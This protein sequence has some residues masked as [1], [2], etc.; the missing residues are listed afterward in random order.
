MWQQIEGILRQAMRETADQTAAF[1]PG[2]LVSLVLFVAV[3]VIAV[4][5][6]VAVIRALKGIEFDR[7]AEQFGISGVSVW[8]TSG[9]LSVVIGRTLQWT[10]L[11]LGLLLSLTALNATIPSRLAIVIIEYVPHLFAALMILV[12][13]WL[14][15]QLLARSTLIGAVNMQIRSARL[16]SLAVKW[17]VLLVAV[18]MALDHLGIG[19][20]VLLL[21]FGILFG[22]IVL[23]ASIA[24]GFGAKDAVSRAIAREI[25]QQSLPEDK[26]NHV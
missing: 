6:R 1:L 9:S 15:S 24:I 26:V 2:V 22:G 18:A 3:A 4:L 25:S 19:R 13:G 7:R 16:V 8:S 21:A 11:I 23:T 17:L 5:V 10:I 12:V 20:S 14:V